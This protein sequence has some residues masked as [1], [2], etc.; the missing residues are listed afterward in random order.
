MY[1][2]LIAVLFLIST[3][4]V[5][6]AWGD[7]GHKIVCEIAFR[8]ALPEVRAEIRRLM[9]GE[10][11]YDFF[12]E[13]CTFP[14]HPRTRDNEHYVNLAR[15]AKGI[16]ATSP[17]PLAPKCVL[18]AI[19]SDM[20]VLASSANDERKLTAL[21]YLGHWVGDLHQPL[22]VSFGDDRGGNEVTTIGECQPNLHSTWDTCLVLRAVGEDPVAA[23][24]ELVKSITPA[25][26]ELWTQASDPRDWANESFAITRAA[27]TR[28]CL[29]QG[30]SCNQPTDDVTVDNAYIQGNRDIVRTQLAKAGVRL[31][32]LLNKAVQP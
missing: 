3:P 31:A 19:E 14:D 23:A 15:T 2:I 26:Q 8:L 11:R 20:A 7:T 28:Y 16:A 10:D 17:C 13:A 4:T 32:H 24:T 25:Q 29:Q 27:A 22:H 9:K 21:K 5:A 18:S 1:R 12:R 30:A 6:S